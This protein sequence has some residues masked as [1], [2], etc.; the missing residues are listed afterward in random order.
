MIQS[1]VPS[2][3]LKRGLRKTGIGVVVSDKMHK[4]IVVALG[5]VSK[6]RL[7][8]KTLRRTTRVKVHDENNE[9]VTGDKVMITSTRPLSKD[10][11]WRLVSVIEKVKK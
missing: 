10:K 2:T 4:T 9:C 7:Y 5:Y 11:C 1:P 3:P 8:K 6:H